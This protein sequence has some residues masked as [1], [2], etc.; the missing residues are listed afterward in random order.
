MRENEGMADL[1]NDAALDRALREIYP[2]APLTLD[3]AADLRARIR[4]RAELPLARRRRAAEVTVATRWGRRIAPFAA[5]ASLAFGVWFGS[6]S[7]S[8]DAAGMMFADVREMIG[9]SD[10][11]LLRAEVSEQDFRLLVSGRADPDGLL[12]IAIG[13]S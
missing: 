6:Y 11:E 5:A 13:E 1:P 12:L 8:G 10:E 4:A 2:P 3:Q 9:A 7:G